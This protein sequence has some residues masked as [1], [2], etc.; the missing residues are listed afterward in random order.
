MALLITPSLSQVTQGMLTV[1]NVALQ[2]AMGCHVFRLLKC[3]LISDS[4]TTIAEPQ[5]SSRRGSRSPL[6][7]L[8]SPSTHTDNDRT[9][10]SSVPTDATRLHTMSKGN[11]PVRITILDNGSHARYFGS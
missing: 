6:S 1:P 11:S 4:A 2:N 7:A 3:G 10:S 5:S 8:Q 9:P